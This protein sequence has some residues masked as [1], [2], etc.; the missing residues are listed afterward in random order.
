MIGRPIAVVV[1]LI[2]LTSTS[3][4]DEPKAF[5]CTFT[6]GVTHSY[7]NGA[8]VA[9]KASPLMFGISAIDTKAQSAELK[10][11]GGTGQLRI[12][13]AVNAMHFLEV[14][15]EGFLHLT[16]VYDKDEAK[17]AYP[18]VH[19]RHFGLFGQPLVTQYQGFCEAAG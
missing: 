19:S 16:T 13:Q 2:L 15:T 17:G 11:R 9:E 4:A 14:V 8:F 7:N 5:N 6:E 18:A 3:A 10:T 12:V 1:L